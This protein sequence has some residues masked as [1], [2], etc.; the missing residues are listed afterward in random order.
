MPQKSFHGALGTVKDEE[1]ED[2]TEDEEDT[3]LIGS[4][5]SLVT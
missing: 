4:S 3:N 2:E 1:T 5:F